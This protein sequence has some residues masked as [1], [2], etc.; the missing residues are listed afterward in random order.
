MKEKYFFAKNV[1]S[2]FA[3]LCIVF[4]P[5]SFSLISFQLE[6][7][8][9]LFGK[10]IGFVSDKFFGTHLK[11]TKVYSDFVSMYILVLL[12]FILAIV[13]TLI[14]TRFN[15]WKQCRKRIFSI[16]YT[17][18]CYYLAVQLL[19]YGFGKLFKDQF[20]L[21]EPN[22]LYTPLGQLDKD[23]LYWSSIGTS[24]MYNLFTGSIEVLAA[25][26]L[27]F[28]RTRMLAALL[29]I[30]LLAQVVIINFS[31]DIS[32][33][34]FS[35]FLFF[36][37]LYVLSPYCQRLYYFLFSKKEVPPPFKADSLIK[38]QF[39]Y[40]FVKCFIAGLI[41]LE[42]L[43]PYV[44]KN[45]F[46]DDLAVRPYMHGAYKVQQVIIN[47]DTITAAELP[48][49]RF[50]IH[51]QS[52]LI[53]QDKTDALQDYKLSYDIDKYEYI[54]TDYQLNKTPLTLSYSQ[55]DSI[56]LLKYSKNYR[57]YQIQGKAIDWRKLPLLK[58]GFHWTV[59]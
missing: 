29:T 54:L 35:F 37:S 17:I 23:I 58:N 7:T 18:C 42:A 47:N 51:R 20:Y 5:F 8:D 39:L 16:C 45:N 14:V 13:A 4:I 30:A 26:L 21:P 31:F 3:I 6:F 41:F 49:K 56:L 2:F 34:L 40:V 59:D 27:F 43:Y 24:R 15:N 44:Q 22:I 1:A 50:F 12:L 25:V 52:Y 28:K 46:N 11:D 36:L 9:L 48:V 33:K 32:V 53:F 19:K 38:N 55:A 57:Q 10:L